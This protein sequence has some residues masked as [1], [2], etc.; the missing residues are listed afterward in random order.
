[1][2]TDSIYKQKLQESFDGLEKKYNYQNLQLTNQKLVI[3]NKQNS[4]YLL[5]SILIIVALIATFIFWRLK[6]NQ[7][8]LAIQIQ[9]LKKETSLFESE[10]EN[11][12]LLK[13][14]LEFLSILFSNIEIHRKNIVK[15]PDL[16]KDSASKIVSDQHNAFYNELTTYIN[17]EYDNFTVRLKEKFPILTERDLIFCC[18]LVAK[19]ESGM[20]ATILGVNIESVNKHRHRLRTKLQLPNSEN[21]VAFLR[22]F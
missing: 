14:Q 20:I 11:S 10:M 3:K 17:V 15:R 19:F 8:Q 9:L 4:L 16:W 12:N 13:K 6:V 5:I 22:N 1:M 21:L 18:L 2:A 7:R